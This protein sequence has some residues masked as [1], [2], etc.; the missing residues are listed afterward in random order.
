MK[1]RD[2]NHV[3]LGPRGLLRA[4][5]T[6]PVLE[7]L[8]LVILALVYVWIV[9]P[10]IDDRI[11]IPFLTIIVLIPIVS[12]LAHGDRLHDM[13]LRFDNLWS[14][15]REVGAA[16]FVGTIL[17]VAVGLAVGAGPA[18]PRGILGY[19]LFY[20]LWG[21]VQQ[22]AMQSFTFRRTLESVERPGASAVITAL[23]F[24]IV[25]WPNWPLA[26]MTG[27]GGY[28]WCLLFYRQP[29]LFTLALSHGWLAV[30]LRYSWPADWIH[31]LRI[32]SNYWTWTP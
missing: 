29:N 28:V 26:L 14:S 6:G 22:Y 30:L 7:P 31:N 1:M 8:V 20:P 18:F 27:V 3:S 9:Q 25:H 13:G 19:M 10:T 17:I 16:T 21:L 24:A 5:T 23:L 4:L 32:G 12:N 2:H 11:R 15:A